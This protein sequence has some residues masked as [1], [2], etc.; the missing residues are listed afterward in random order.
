MDKENPQIPL[1]CKECTE[2]FVRNVQS[3]YLEM[4]LQRLQNVYLVQSFYSMTQKIGK[5]KNTDSI[6]GQGEKF[7]T[8]LQPT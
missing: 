6:Q 1:F 2:Y 7:Y 5:L 3:I 8:S 4:D